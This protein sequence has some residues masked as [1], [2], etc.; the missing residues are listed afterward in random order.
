M[1][2]TEL[3]NKDH[4][5]FETISDD[6]PQI[7]ISELAEMISMY[8][9]EIKSIAKNLEEESSPLPSK[10]IDEIENLMDTRPN[11]DT[12]ISTMEQSNLSTNDALDIVKTLR[13]TLRK[14]TEYDRVLSRIENRISLE[15]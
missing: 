7:S 8:Y 10:D 12:V 14:K 15:Y 5:R 13:K 9:D 3:K 1:S 4:S 11:L 2:K 6:N